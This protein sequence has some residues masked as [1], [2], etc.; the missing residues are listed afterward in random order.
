MAK[1]K[2][3]LIKFGVYRIYEV[4]VIFIFCTCEQIKQLTLDCF[5]F[6]MDFTTAAGTSIDIASGKFNG[7]VTGF[8]DASLNTIVHEII[9]TAGFVFDLIG[10]KPVFDER[11]AYSIGDMVDFCMSIGGNK[12]STYK[13][14]VKQIKAEFKIKAK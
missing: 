7:V 10:E 12:G 4:P 1:V 9:H 2:E 11:L 13:E 6:E 5:N 8:H 3:Q 14:V